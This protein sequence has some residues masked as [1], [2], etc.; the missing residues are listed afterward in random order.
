MSEEDECKHGLALGTCSLCLGG[1]RPRRQL[2]TLRAVAE[3]TSEAQ[4]DGRCPACDCNIYQGDVIY[5]QDGA[6]I[7]CGREADPLDDFR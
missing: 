2:H 5:L 3:A 7:C 4:Y 1:T 6:W